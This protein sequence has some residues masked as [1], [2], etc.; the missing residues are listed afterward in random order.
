MTRT[1]AIAIAPARFIF[2]LLLCSLTACGYA[3]F[4]GP[5]L[6]ADT[7]IHATLTPTTDPGILYPAH[8]PLLIGVGDELAVHLFG[9]PDFT[10]S[11]ERVGLDGSL[12]VPLVGPVAVLGL[13]LRQGAVAVEEK[14]KNAGMYRDPQVT[15]QLIDSPSQV[16]T[17]TGEMHGFIPVI[18]HRTLFSVLS[19]AGQYPITGSHTIVIDRPGVPDPIVIN[20]GSDPSRSAQ[21]NVPVFAGDTVVVP[22]TG[23]VYMLGS[24]K[25]QS[26]VPLQQN[27]PLTLMQAATLAG[28]PSFDAKYKDLRIVRTV[29]FERKV[30]KL[31]MKAVL[32]GKA[33][34]PVL[35]ADDIVYLP[36]DLLKASLTNGGF[37][38]INSVASLL[39]IAFQNSNF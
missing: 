23:V 9:V 17:V 25:N 27:S 31:D 35:Q 32:N 36:S 8:R 20:L 37:A 6:G 34:D 26:A 3:Q 24:F 29:G 28:G 12:Q 10:T 7:Q 38:A 33:A 39:L 30:V 13:T 18:G 16:V 14:L 2:F 4:N 19:A 15:M 1:S 5:S 22:R 21:A 11:P